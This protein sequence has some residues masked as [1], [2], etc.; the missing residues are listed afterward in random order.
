VGPP[1]SSALDPPAFSLPPPHIPTGYVSSRRTAETR[2]TLFRTLKITSFLVCFPQ[3]DNLCTALT[4]KNLR[5]RPPLRPEG[6]MCP[7]GKYYFVLQKAHLFGAFT[8]SR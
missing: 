4:V 1:A 8:A 3:P 7:P 6:D 5:P 2:R